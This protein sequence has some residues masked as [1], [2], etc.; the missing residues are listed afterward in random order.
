MT[1]Q[2][3]SCLGNNLDSD[4]GCLLLGEKPAEFVA[5]TAEDQEAFTNVK[6]DMCG[7]V[8]FF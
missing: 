4:I 5:A 3:G 7:W 6:L 8:S 2:L 1:H